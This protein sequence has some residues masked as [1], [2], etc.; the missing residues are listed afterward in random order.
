MITAILILSS[1]SALL[2]LF[3]ITTALR[4]LNWH[5]DKEVEK[6]EE[7]KKKI[8]KATETKK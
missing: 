6:W 5:I 1:V 3:A 8:E 2:S 7:F 4:H